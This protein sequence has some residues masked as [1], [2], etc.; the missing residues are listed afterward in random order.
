ME[1]PARVALTHKRVIR[2]TNR[3]LGLA[4]GA[5]PGAGWNT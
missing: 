3:R 1:M 5:E 2:H 4:T